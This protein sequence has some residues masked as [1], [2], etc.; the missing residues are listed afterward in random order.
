MTDY[1]SVK[2][3]TLHDHNTL[4]KSF[5][6]SQNKEH[7]TLGTKYFVLLFMSEIL[8]MPSWGGVSTFLHISGVGR[9]PV[10]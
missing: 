6:Q 7:G 10:Q 9:Q 8:N 1:L 3:S 4:N 5:Q 2:Q